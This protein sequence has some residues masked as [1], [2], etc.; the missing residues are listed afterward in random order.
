MSLN[1]TPSNL[2]KETL[3]HF[4]RHTMFWLEVTAFDSSFTL[5]TTKLFI[6]YIERS[7]HQDEVR[8]AW[9]QEHNIGAVLPPP[10][11][12]GEGSVEFI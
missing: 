10:P 9:K 8:L 6:E 2:S 5:A 7:D 11:P 3:L 12:S 1:I 4:S